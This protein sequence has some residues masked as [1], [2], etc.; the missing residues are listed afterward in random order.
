MSTAACETGITQAIGVDDPN[1]YF[2][3]RV[4]S[5]ASGRVTERLGYLSLY[6]W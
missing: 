3:L 2:F 5:E 4:V 6:A 1:F